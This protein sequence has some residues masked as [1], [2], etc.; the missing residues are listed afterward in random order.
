[1]SYVTR[2]M[3]AMREGREYSPGDIAAITHLTERDAGQC[4]HQLCKG[5]VIECVAQ[6]R[7]RKNRK[8]KTRQKGLL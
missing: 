2:V 6:D 1:M 5:G 4:L 8:Y 7:Y 3:T